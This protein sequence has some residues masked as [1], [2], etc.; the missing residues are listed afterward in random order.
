MFWRPHHGG[1]ADKVGFLIANAVKESTVE[2]WPENWATWCLFRD[3]RN[4]WR[5]GFNGPTGMDFNVL[6]RDLDDLGITG[7]ERLRL[8]A[9]MRAMEQAALD[10]FYGTT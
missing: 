9:D 7:D 1:E 2:V 8:K 10:S 4:Q 6:Y 5:I 3:Q